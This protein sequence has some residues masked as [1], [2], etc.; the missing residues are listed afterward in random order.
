M[1]TW[2]TILGWTALA[3]VYAAYVPW[4]ARRL[5]PARGQQT[6]DRDRFLLVAPIGIAAVAAG[7]S[8][9]SWTGGFGFAIFGLVAV[10][11]QAATLVNL[12]HGIRRRL[13]VK[14]E[15]RRRRIDERAARRRA[16]AGA[17]ERYGQPARRP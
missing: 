6:P 15:D 10:R 11:L 4:V 5:R 12:V 17:M 7:V 8:L 16:R 1:D 3:V 2:Q 14:P 9:E 13:P